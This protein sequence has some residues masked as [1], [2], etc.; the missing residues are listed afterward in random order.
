MSLG[1]GVQDDGAYPESK[2]GLAGLN[3]GI[4]GF[5][6]EQ[7]ALWFRVSGTTASYE[8]VTQSSGFGGPAI[9]YWVSPKFA[10]EGGAGVG[11]WD[12]EGVNESG[13]GILLGGTFVFWTN[14]SHS[15]SVG[16]ELASA[17]TDPESVQNFGFVLGWQKN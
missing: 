9:Q 1:A 15:F 12:I 16:A 10:I 7:T 13:L 17:M 4:G 3:L 14:G 5:L 6:N 8:G 2:T 11:F